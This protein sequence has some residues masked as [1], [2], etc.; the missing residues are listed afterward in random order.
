MKKSLSVLFV[1]IIILAPLFANSDKEI[2]LDRRNIVR[3]QMAEQSMMIV[4]TEQVFIRNGDQDHKFRPN[5]D[6]WYLTGFKEPESAIIITS[7]EITFDFDG[8]T[9]SGNEFLFLRERNP[10]RESWT[11]LRVGV[12]RAPEVLGISNALPINAFG[13]VLATIVDG[14]KTMY[15]NMNDEALKDPTNALAQATIQWL[16]TEPV[17]RSDGR[18]SLAKRLRRFISRKKAYQE[19]IKPAEEIK[20]LAVSTIT[21]QMRMVK[22]DYEQAIMEESVNIT[23]KGLIAAMKRIEPGLYEH[24]IQATIEFTYLDNHA[25]RE[26]YESIIGSGPNALI[27]HYN[28]NDRIMEDGD[29]VL[30]DVGAEYN[31]YTADITRTVPVNGEFT[32]AQAE[33]YNVVLG[34]Q[35]AVYEAIKPGVTLQEL[36]KISR[37]FMTDKGYGKYIMHGMAHHLGLDVHDVTDRSLPLLPGMVITVEPG[38]YIPI[39]DESMTPEYRGIGI[40]IEDDI[41]MTVDGMKRLSAGIPVTVEEIESVMAQ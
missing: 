23:G 17:D 9:Y 35:H 4:L 24:Q 37:D 30:M 8:K 13:D 10:Q 7:S 6:F 15:I 26:G 29:L 39:D 14:A 1:I 28:E 25:K 22:S 27:L 38:L 19:E 16:P 31:M 33:V 36:N 32:P 3:E 2:F 5:S 11:G 41:L 34:A 21:T 40:R 18:P 20:Y 12:E